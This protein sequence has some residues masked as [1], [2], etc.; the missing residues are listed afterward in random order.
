MKFSARPRLVRLIRR[1]ATTSALCGALVP[2][3]C[4]GGGHAVPAAIRPSGGGTVPVRTGSSSHPNIVFVLTDDLSANLLR[5]M[6]H[7]QAMQAAGATFEN[8]FVAD[9]LCC[10]SRASIFTGEF[11]HNT[12]VL[13]NFGADGGYGVFHQRGEERRTFAIPLRRAGYLTA[14]MGK[15]LNGYLQAGDRRIDGSTAHVT[16]GYVPP[17]WTE[18]DV[19]G[20][21]YGGFNYHLSESGV[22]HWYAHSR[23]DYLTDVLARKGVQFINSAA[24]RH[25]PFFL[26]L[27]TFAPHAP[28]TPAPRN[29]RDFPNL[30]VP[31]GPS[32]NRLPSDP[33][34]WLRR[35]PRLS[36]RQISVINRM[37]RRR[38]RAVEAVDRMVG[39][40]QDALRASGVS[41]DTYII[42]SSDNG[43]HMGQYRLT[44]GKGTAFDT[45]IRVPL[46]VTGPGITG[47]AVL[48]QLVENIDLAETFAAIGHTQLQGDGHS[49]V[50]VLHGAR[51]SGWRNAVLFEHHSAVGSAEVDPDSQPPESGNPGSY[52]AIRAS[53]FLYVEY[54]DGEIEFYD[55]RRDPSELHNIAGR[56][57]RRQR[58]QLHRELHALKYCSGATGCWKAMHLPPLQGRW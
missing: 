46:I 58:L 20:W 2:A 17:G 4:G 32:F 13:T 22:L 53:G 42:F 6:P 25:R 23:H 27:S 45:D 24:R 7:V 37:F 19:A 29:A 5:F 33:P 49:R 26:E 56:L 31:R 8:Y 51:R 18:W 50:G 39:K 47:G 11:P 44:E 15:Y 10:P 36:A 43:L 35:R 12:G 3:A 28:F 30:K 54:A 1:L 41:S 52:H 40:I 34:S 55:L 38:A 48:P 9:S 14:L 21:A 16:R 57:S